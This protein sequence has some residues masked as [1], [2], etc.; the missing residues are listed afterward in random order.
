MPFY[1]SGWRR[2]RRYRKYRRF[3][4]RY[5]RRSYARRYVNGST[6][7]SIR[8]KTAI[9]NTQVWIA[10][11]GPDGSGALIYAIEP[12]M[13]AQGDRPWSLAQSQLYRAYCNLYEEVKIIG[14]KVAMAIVSPVGGADIPSLQIYTA[15][16]RKRGY[17]EPGYTAGDI[18]NAATQ[19]VATCINNNVAKISRSIWASDLMEKATWIDTD[20]DA[21]DYYIN[22]AWK[23]ANV[24]PQ[25]FH[26][27]FWCFLNCPNLNATHAVTVS[28]SVTYYVA[29][30][31]PKYGGAGG[32]QRLVDLG[33]RPIDEGDADGGGDM[34]VVVI[35]DDD[36]VNVPAR[37][38]ASL[39]DA[40][41]SRSAANLA[42]VQARDR[43]N[44][45]P[46]RVH[47]PKNV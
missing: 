15:W 26:P 20:M 30:R 31:N 2:Y 40:P 41:Q 47:R 5:G 37:A 11:H 14:M 21:D 33:P 25:M 16:D 17:T 7:S 3:Y 29:F 13:K 12:Y 23:R 32:E 43:L 28:I 18:Q 4:K 44:P 9:T 36:D 24:N 42:A 39:P 27:A 45:G 22:Q 35:D 38:S 8:M 46:I 10:G 19:T 6:R 34:D 1:R